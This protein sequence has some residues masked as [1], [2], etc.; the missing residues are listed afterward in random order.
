MYIWRPYSTSAFPQAIILRLVLV[1]VVLALS[2]CGAPSSEQP[3]EPTSAEPMSTEPMSTEPSST[4]NTTQMT[5]TE[6]SVERNCTTPTLCEFMSRYEHQLDM[7]PPSL[8]ISAN[9][10]LPDR[11]D[12]PSEQFLSNFYSRMR[13]PSPNKLC[14]TAHSNQTVGTSDCRWEYEC[15]YNAKRIPPYLF[16]AKCINFITAQYRCKKVTYPVPVLYTTG[17]DI[18][19]KKSNWEWRLEQIAVACVRYWAVNTSPCNK[20]S[21]T[22]QNSL[23]KTA[24]LDYCILIVNS[25]L[26]PPPPPPPK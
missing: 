5:P 24:Q 18:F 17:C 4:G 10:T 26:S 11:F 3:T 12:Q 13:M 14:G 22:T 21:L 7:T 25:H 16:H 23:P 15:D 8:Q 19:T 20:V 2:V 1:G 6:V 9:V